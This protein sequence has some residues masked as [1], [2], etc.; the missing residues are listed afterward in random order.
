MCKDKVQ[1]ER[2]KIQI[3]RQLVIVVAVV[4]FIGKAYTLNEFDGALSLFKPYSGLKGHPI[5]TVT[6]SLNQLCHYVFI[7]KTRAKQDS[8]LFGPFDLVSTLFI[9]RYCLVIIDHN[10]K[11]Q[12]TYTNALRPL[13]EFG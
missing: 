2:Y 7:H 13:F 4:E 10:T 1:P 5:R 8:I 9:E 11:I 6:S 12:T 3:A